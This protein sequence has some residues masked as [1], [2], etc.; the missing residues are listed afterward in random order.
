MSAEVVGE[1]LLAVRDALLFSCLV[2]ARLAPRRRVA[3][4]DERAGHRV[5]RVGVNLKEAVFVLTK[6][7]RKRLER[8]IRSEPDELRAVLANR[9]NEV[10]FEA[11]PQPAVDAVRAHDEISAIEFL[12]IRHLP[13]EI[14]IH[15]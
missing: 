4:D 9:W 10:C 13:P 12:R 6:E 15:P 3:F 7:E 5:E 11:F 2:E 8:D 1:E 14:Q